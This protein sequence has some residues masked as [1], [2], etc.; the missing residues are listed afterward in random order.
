MGAKI[1]TPIVTIIK[2]VG[3]GIIWCA[4]EVQLHVALPPDLAQH[5]TLER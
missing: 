3:T 2:N 4:F 5:D 1:D